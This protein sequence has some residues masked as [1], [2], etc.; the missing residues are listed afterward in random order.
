MSVA[1]KSRDG[2]VKQYAT[3]AERL[4]EVHTSPKAFEMIESIPVQCAEHWLW[5]AVVEIDGK[6]YL[7]HAVV[8]LQSTNAAEAKDPWATA[9]TSAVGRALAF[10]GWLS[11]GSIA[12]ADELLRGK[13]A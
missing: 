4:H 9:E 3:V 10:A 1:I 2:K 11:D 13:R 6:R 7:G 8:N 5:R 12:S